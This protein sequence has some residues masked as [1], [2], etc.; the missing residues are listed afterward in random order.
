MT[1]P[2]ARIVRS[3]EATRGT[4]LLASG[5]NVA[6]VRRMAREELEARLVAERIVGEAHEKAAALVAEARERA[7]AAGAE[8][9]RQAREAGE[10]ALLARWVALRDAE[11]RRAGSD[12]DRLV[13]LAV[14]LAERLV[15]ATLEVAP[16]RIATLATAVLA[17]ARGARRAIIEA[18]PQDADELRRHLASAGLD[19][20][21]FEVKVDPA[22]ARGALRLHTDVGVIDAHLAPRLERLADALRDAL[23]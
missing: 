5:A 2:R 8:A 16:S 11:A 15:G 20:A 23:R 14:L 21:S 9:L 10:A 22:L 17:E 1:V 7:T 18:N 6:V 12:V 4:P 19:S 13:S 3:E